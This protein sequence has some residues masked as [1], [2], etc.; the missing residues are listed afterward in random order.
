MA[1]PLVD[2][3]DTDSSEDASP[4]QE[5]QARKRR[6]LSSSETTTSSTPTASSR[7]KAAAVP[8]PPA[9]FY[10]L[11]ATNVRTTTAD[12]PAL[13]GGRKRQVAHKEG[14]W[15]TH[16]YLE[17]MPLFLSLSL[18]L[19]SSATFRYVTQLSDVPTFQHSQGTRTH[20]KNPRSAP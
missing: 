20:S 18:A 14:N 11:Y 16:I 7:G 10:S 17:C 5:P 12:D 19:A 2:Y 1:P 8:A 4:S 15:P 13:H 6:K 9:S 3:R